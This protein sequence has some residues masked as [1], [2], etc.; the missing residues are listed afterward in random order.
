MVAWFGHHGLIDD[1]PLVRSR[2]ATLP[3]QIA[4]L[5]VSCLHW[6][7]LLDKNDYNPRIIHKQIIFMPFRS[8]H[9]SFLR[10]TPLGS[11]VDA[12]KTRN[13]LK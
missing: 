12:P 1:L 6:E 8:A 7:L 3:S 10:R 2:E 4:K 11:E 13:Y 9:P 5:F